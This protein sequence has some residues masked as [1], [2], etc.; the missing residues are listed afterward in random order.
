VASMGTS[1]TEKQISTL[2]RLTKNVAFALDA[3]AAGE[4]AMQRGVGY[5]N[6]LEA[7]VRVIILPAGKDPDN[8]IKEDREKWRSLTEQAIPV[9]DYI[10]NTAAAKLDLKTARDKSLAVDRLLP[11]VAE[12]KD[13]V[14]QAHYLQKL[15]QMVKISEQSLDAALGK[16]KASQG[17]RQPRE[18][19]TEVVRRALRPLLSSPLEEYCLALLLQ[20][21]ELKERSGELPAEYFE[22]SE[23]REILT[24]LKQAGGP[25]ALK[26][27][28]DAALHDRADSLSRRS[29]P[30]DQIEEKYDDCVLNL[31]KK[32]LQN[33][34]AKRAEIFALEAESMGTGA[35]L[36]KL[37]S[38]GME[39]SI[40][41][42]DIFT[43][44]ARRG[45]EPR[46]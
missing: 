1:V 19:K 31:R 6:V 12:I 43:K 41:L 9:I 29:L 8:V 25:A 30:S 5:E 37:E 46:R 2:K 36:A 16:L 33:L 39:P 23:N 27:Q 40:Q 26:D 18:P 24:A 28:L 32:F 45:Q 20:H 22:S 15:A 34:E 3:D 7:E 35:D 44:K 14:R 13:A 21:P 4:E 10:F 11:V 42:K 38:D 17:R